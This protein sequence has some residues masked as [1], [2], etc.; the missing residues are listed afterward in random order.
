MAN[1]S[2]RQSGLNLLSLDGGG[3]TGLSSLLI[4]K[5]I[6]TRLQG[7]G[8]RTRH[9]ITLKPCDYF[10]MIAGTGT[11]AISAVMLGRLHMTIDE[12]IISYSRL[13]R[14]VFSERKLAT[15]GDS[16]AYK[17]TVL[18][19]ELKGI[20]RR[21]TGNEEVTMVES[22]P[23]DSDVRCKVVIYAMSSYNMTSALPVT[24]RSYSTP[25]TAVP[26]CAIWEVLRATTTHPELFKSIDIDTDGTGLR[27]K[28]VH[29]GLVCSNPTAQL[30]EEAKREY[31]DRKVSS[32]V[33]IGSGHPKT[34]QV[35]IGGSL[36]HR[37]LGEST[38]R[39][40]MQAAH[41]MAEGSERVAEE[42]ERRFADVSSVY[43]RLNIQQGAQGVRACEWE[44][45][46]EMAA[47]TRAYLH[48]NGIKSKLD[49]LVEA[50]SDRVPILGT[51]Q[52]DGRVMR[53]SKPV[54]DAI[55]S[56]P[57]SSIRFTGREKHTEKVRVYFT[58]GS[59]G[60]YV[61]VLYGL[62]G[63][64][65]TQIAL[66]CVEQL[67]ERFIHVFF[68]DAS[69]DESIQTSLA[70][71]AFNSSRGKTYEDMLKWISRNGSNCLVVFDNADDPNINLQ[72]Y[73]PQ[74]ADY[75]V[76]ITTR[77]PELTGLAENSNAVCNVSGLEE[78]E[79]VELLLKTAKL[80][81]DQMDKE[82]KAAMYRLLK[83]FDHLALAVVQAGAYIQ[84]MQLSLT[85]YW[86]RYS[87]RQQKLL[88]DKSRTRLDGYTRSIYTTWE[89]SL[90]QLS[91]YAKQ[92]LFLI[93]FLHRD[94]IL[95]EIFERAT[96]NI[97]TYVP[98]IP[99]IPEQLSIQQ[100]VKLFLSHLIDNG[101]W[102]N[103]F[104]TYIGELMSFSLATFNQQTQAY[105]VHTLVRDWAQEAA[106][107][108]NITI[109]H[110]ALLLAISVDKG[111]SSVDYAY[112]RKILPHIELIV[113]QIQISDPNI[114]D[115]FAEVYRATGRFRNE[116]LLREQGVSIRK[117]QLG[118]Q[119]P[120]TLAAMSSLAR[121]YQKQRRLTEAKALQEVTLESQQH[122]LGEEHPDTLET[123]H[124]LAWT[125]YIEGQYA[126]AKALLTTVVAVQKRILGNNHRDTL[127]SMDD[128]AS[129]YEGEG[130]LTVAEELRLTV[131]ASRKQI[132]GEDHADTMEGMGNLAVTYY[133]QGRLKEAEALY[134]VVVAARRRILGEDHPST[135]N[136][137]HGLA[138]TYRK[139]GRIADAQELYTAVIVAQKRVLGEDHPDTLVSM[140]NV[141]YTYQLQGQFEDA[142][143]A[144]AIHV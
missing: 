33:S 10:D 40:V 115:R 68:V 26:N 94:G 126:E 140:H 111:K 130:Q 19:Q 23:S 67:R 93:A 131:M 16:G 114:S 142:E 41:E 105:S 84:K 53:S 143:A 82:N 134:V 107:R 110:S 70:T 64:G 122:I 47:H 31:P 83:R 72:T 30:L 90:N 119:H 76:L 80:R 104:M 85:Q 103:S 25:T 116:E 56:C 60:R 5:E 128:L 88:K 112:N 11:G 91:S 124:R 2:D 54:Q 42:M 35:E 74:S 92:V 62:G 8:Q 12:A 113:E 120:K 29:G 109:Q 66:R 127:E 15:R 73:M 144:Y 43:C 55:R 78:H 38:M 121:A 39:R 34:I 44:R 106:S 61:F 89:L 71:I 17:A 27:H 133:A 18:E 59:R 57:P 22:D 96:R 20:I 138:C 46:D 123:M 52:L 141:A 9:Q 135:L 95:E 117:Q 51:A 37:I 97:R 3:I 69:S 87:T 32:I 58:S 75:N 21:S 118:E 65:K 79:A 125:F 24:F 100:Q 77:C 129:A 28:F 63:A 13:M 14:T 102:N 4:I 36:R 137:T 101:S 7:K 81:L 139:Q 136:S 50:I 99:P 6:M 45:M 1:N 108:Q 86:D 48:Q 98:D 132:L 49:R